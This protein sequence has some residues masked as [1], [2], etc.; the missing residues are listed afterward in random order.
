MQQ[1]LSCSS[2]QNSIRN[3]VAGRVNID[4]VVF[5]LDGVPL[6][7]GD[8]PTNRYRK[9]AGDNQLSIGQ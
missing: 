1:L 7:V 2:A 4:D 3:T 9:A 5:D 6:S 8:S